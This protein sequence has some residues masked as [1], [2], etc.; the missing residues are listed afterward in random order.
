MKIIFS[1][2]LLSVTPLLVLLL[3]AEI[4]LSVVYYQIRGQEKLALIG[5][6]KQVRTKYL[7]KRAEVYVKE[8]FPPDYRINLFS[9]QGKLMLDELE[10]K[11]AKYFSTFVDEVENIDAKLIVIYVPSYK[12]KDV[13]AGS[14]IPC[15]NFFTELTKE[16]EVDFVNIADSLDKYEVTEITLLPIDYHP[17]RYGHQI[18]AKLLYQTIQGYTF[19]FNN[20]INSTD[21]SNHAFGYIKPNHQ[22]VTNRNNELVHFWRV[23][24][25]G[26]RMNTDIPSKKTKSRILIMGDSITFG[27]NVNN[28]DTYSS[29]IN[30]NFPELLVINGGISGSSIKTQLHNF[31]N[32]C[33]SLMPDLV[34][35]QVLDN[36]IYGMFSFSVDSEYLGE[37]TLSENEKQF[38]ELCRTNHNT[39]IQ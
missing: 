28:Q 17:S 29:L 33:K 9:P 6:Y 26:F 1:R 19:D 23:N 11:Y 12:V 31:V 5:V 21:Y 10:I 32:S 18:I 35:L 7:I 27:A 15:S 4:G 3:I 24:N 39:E 20:S 25:L 14:R 8:K 37:S 2:L 22:G 30:D 13:L 16:L 38:V 36:D 34:I